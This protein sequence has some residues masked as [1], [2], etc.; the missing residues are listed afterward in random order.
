MDGLIIRIDGSPETRALADGIRQRVFIEE[1]GVPRDEIFDELNGIATHIIILD[2]DMPIAT[3]RIIDEGDAWRIGLV[4]VE[5]PM[6]GRG[7]GERIMRIAMDYIISRSGKEI[8]LTAQ[9]D[10]CKFYEKL[11]FDKFG[12]NIVFESGVTLVPMK[13]RLS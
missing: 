3:A 6:R 13:Q 4:A 8:I 1:Q 2:G 10:V 5:K 12:D 7:L 11:G 9:Q